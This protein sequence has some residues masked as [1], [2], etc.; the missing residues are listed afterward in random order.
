MI[1]SSVQI[2]FEFI[3]VIVFDNVFGENFYWLTMCRWYLFLFL[4]LYLATI[5]IFDWRCDLLF[6]ADGIFS[7]ICIC[8][9]ICIWREFLLI[10][11]VI[12][13]SVQMVF[14]VV[15]VSV[16][17]FVFGENCYWLT[18]WF[19][20]LCRWYLSSLCTSLFEEE[21]WLQSGK[22][23]SYCL[24]LIFTFIFT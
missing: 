15:F 6:C 16:S 9:C 19:A 11:D 18:M 14:L 13:S 7:C 1:C 2:I 23:P 20:L 22:S 3:I 17:V 12:C 10:D 24:Q 5:I 8:I 21:L 4:Y